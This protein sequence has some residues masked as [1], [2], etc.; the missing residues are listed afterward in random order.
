MKITVARLVLLMA[1]TG[2]AVAGDRSITPLQGFTVNPHVAVL[3]IRKDR[4]HNQAIQGLNTRIGILSA[5]RI[6]TTI[7]TTLQ[8]TQ[9][10]TMRR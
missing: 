9:A 7:V 3:A 5:A 10:I 6:P 8:N 1:S 2:H 4:H